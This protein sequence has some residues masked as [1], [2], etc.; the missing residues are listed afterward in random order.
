MLEN[1]VAINHYLKKLNLGTSGFTF[2]YI[3][4]GIEIS[5]YIHSNPNKR[6]FISLVV[7]YRNYISGLISF[8]LLLNKMNKKTGFLTWNQLINFDAG[9]LFRMPSTV[10]DEWH[11]YKIDWAYG[12]H[13]IKYESIIYS[14][15]SKEVKN[16]VAN[17]ELKKDK[18]PSD[19][20]IL[21]TSEKQMF[22]QSRKDKKDNNELLNLIFSEEDLQYHKSGH[23][24]VSVILTHKQDI[25][26]SEINEKIF[27]KESEEHID[28]IHGIESSINDFIYLKKENE[29]GVKWSVLCTSSAKLEID[30]LKQSESALIIY[31]SNRAS[32]GWNLFDNDLFDRNSVLSINNPWDFNNSQTK[33]D[34][35]EEINDGEKVDDINLNNAF[36]SINEYL[37]NYTLF[38]T[39]L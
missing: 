11:S 19:K 16:L 9:T 15:I 10:D 31:D 39:N 1:N 3:N 4:L 12:T 32:S 20:I 36:T 5:E 14:G 26:I 35:E 18:L 24:I 29:K 38:Q 21:E 33:N 17:F 37:I 13:P 6:L 28:K 30:E 25:I 34:F 8:G 7:P 23:G 22:R 27:R 2:K